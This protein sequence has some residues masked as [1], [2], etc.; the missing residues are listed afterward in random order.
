ME[1]ESPVGNGILYS[2]CTVLLVHDNMS[3][4]N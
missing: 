1:L 2:S 3:L 4:L